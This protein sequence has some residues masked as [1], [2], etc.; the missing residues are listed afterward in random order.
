MI[1]LCEARSRR[2]GSY[3]ADGLEHKIVW[4]AATGSSG[5][6]LDWRADLSQEC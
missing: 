4:W 2:S 3:G 6:G 5:G 1:F